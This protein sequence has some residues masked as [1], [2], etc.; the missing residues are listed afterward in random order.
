MLMRDGSTRPPITTKAF[1]PIDEED[2]GDNLVSYELL[3]HGD[4]STLLRALD[5]Q[6]LDD[7]GKVDRIARQVAKDYEDEGAAE[8][9]GG[10]QG[11]CRSGDACRSSATGLISVS[12][13]FDRKTD[14]GVRPLTYGCLTA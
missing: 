1:L 10:C 13:A 11:P 7:R 9:S 5:F 3:H 6:A 14:G 2:E 8:L 12:S 4:V